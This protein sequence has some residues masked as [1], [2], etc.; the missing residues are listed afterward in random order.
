MSCTSPL[1]AYRTASG[2][3]VFNE[4]ER[5]ATTT[6]LDLACGQC[7][8]CRI[9]RSS[10]WAARVMHE[11]SL[12]PTNSFVTLT[13]DDDNLPPGNSL[14]YRDFQLFLK[15][16]RFHYKLPIR[17]YMCG[18]YGSQ[19]LRPHYHACLF[20][21]SFPDQKL[22]RKTDADSYIYSSPTLD[23]LWPFGHSSIGELNYQTAAYTA[24]YIMQK[25]TGDAADKHYGGRTPE[26]N[27]MSLRP[28]IGAQWFE[29]F[30]RDV[31]DQDYLVLPGGRRT[32]PPT[33]YDKLRKRQDESSFAS[34][35]EARE[36]KAIPYRADQTAERLAV[37]ATVNSARI[38]NLKRNLK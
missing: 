5:H 15:R 30:H 17:F 14:N 9:S 27:R 11:A 29:R 4:L 25:I 37:K 36:L 23:K 16:L 10:H 31:Y 35:L 22:W 6:Q 2:G 13:Y 33:Y 21:I 24:R 18:E 20:N 32:T 7:V 3:V 19:T 1:R 8:A 38:R 28:G 12:Y 26:F 34:T